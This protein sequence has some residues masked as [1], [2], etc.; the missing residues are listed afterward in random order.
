MESSRSMHVQ[1]LLANNAS[2][3]KVDDSR[4]DAYCCA[5]AISGNS[6]LVQA[7]LN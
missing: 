6:A 4:A 3:N 5:A 2:P 7:L 1:L